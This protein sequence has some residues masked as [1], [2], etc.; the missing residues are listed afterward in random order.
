MGITLV[1]ISKRHERLVLT[2]TEMQAKALFQQ[3]VITRRWIADHGGVFVEKL[4]WVKP[5]PYLPDSLIRD[6]K[7]KWYVKENPAMVTKQLSQYAQKEGLY[8]FH[9]TSLKLLNPENA[10]TILKGMR[11]R[12]LKQKKTER[13]IKC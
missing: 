3:I 6:E 10:L 9:I 13:L 2:Q 12:I 7:G 5:N 11:F 8:F 4:P 1:V